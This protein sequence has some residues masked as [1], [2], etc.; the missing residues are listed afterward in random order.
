MRRL[1]QWLAGDFLEVDERPALVRHDAFH[2][3]AGHDGLAEH[4]GQQDIAPHRADPAPAGF[5]QLTL[6]RCW[7]ILAPGQAAPA[8][9]QNVGAPGFGDD[10]CAVDWRGRFQ[11][12]PATGIEVEHLG[13]FQLGRTVERQATADRS[14]CRFDLVADRLR[15]QVR[16]QLAEGLAASE[17]RALLL[18]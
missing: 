2:V 12:D 4:Q 8:T 7:G 3:P 1:Q 6:G 17:F 18:T 5:R 14:L 11:A 10:P 13:L 15:G 9:H 16:M